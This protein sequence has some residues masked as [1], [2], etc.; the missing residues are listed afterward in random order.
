[1]QIFLL[2]KILSKICRPSADILRGR[3]PIATRILHL[4]VLIKSVNGRGRRIF[5]PI[6]T[7]AQ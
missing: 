6:E 2:T 5:L 1:M 7:P 4:L 3:P